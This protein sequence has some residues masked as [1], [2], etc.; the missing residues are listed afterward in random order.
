MDSELLNA[1]RRWWLDN[2]R[3]ISRVPTDDEVLSAYALDHIS[4]TH[5]DNTGVVVPC[6]HDGLRD[7]LG[8]VIGY[9]IGDTVY[10]PEDVTIVRSVPSQGGRS[11]PAASDPAGTTIR[12]G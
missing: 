11:R 7:H 12:C 1:A 10:A 9:K 4:I 8:P 5:I 3:Y 2:G 6:W